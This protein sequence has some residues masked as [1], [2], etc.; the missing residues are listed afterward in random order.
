[1]PMSPAL[2]AIVDIIPQRNQAGRR[3]PCFLGQFPQSRHPG[4]LTGVEK[5][6]GKPKAVSPWSVPIAGH[7]QNT[8][9]GQDRHDH[10]K[11]P[12]FNLPEVGDDMAG[13]HLDLFAEHAK[14][15]SSIEG[16]GA[17]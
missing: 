12:Q 4:R 11:I 2:I 5:A 6:A 10:G 3:Q 16:K 15:G 7:G 1:M 9:I 17:G 14:V 13:C 8:P